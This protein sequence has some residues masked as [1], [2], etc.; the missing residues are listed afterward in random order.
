MESDIFK[1][2]REVEDSH[3]WFLARRSIIHHVLSTLNLPRSSKILDIGS[4]TG[5]NLQ[6]LSLFGNVI[7]IEKDDD[8]RQLALERGIAPIMKGSLPDSIPCIPQKFDLIIMLDVLEHISNDFEAL[9]KVKQLLA[10]NGFLLITVPACPFLWSDHDIQHHHKRRYSY[11]LLK[12]QLQKSKFHIKHITYYN[13]GL[14]PLIAAI[15]LLRKIWP[16]KTIGQDN[17]LPS[18]LLN[19]LLT[20]F[21]ASEKHLVTRTRLPFGTSLL[22]IATHNFLAE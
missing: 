21:F 15:R 22:A 16:S 11:D 13:T 2:M 8:A 20:L 5:G 19:K 9:K 17:H 12:N 14:F 6:M 3:W 18:P 1:Q 7:G 10:P 4:G